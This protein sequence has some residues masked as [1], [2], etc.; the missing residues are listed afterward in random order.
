MHRTR[1]QYDFTAPNRNEYEPNMNRIGMNM[2]DYT[3]YKT[4][5]N[6][7]CTYC[8]NVSIYRLN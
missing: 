1:P 2:T 6:A 7:M 8:D 4:I 3:S 5:Q